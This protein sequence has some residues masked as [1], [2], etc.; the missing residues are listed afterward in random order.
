MVPLDVDAIEKKARAA[1]SADAGIRAEFISIES[2]IAYEK[3]TARG[4]VRILSGGG[5]HTVAR[6]DAAPARQADDHDQGAQRAWDADPKLRAEFMNLENYHAYLKAM[7]SGRVK[8]LGKR[9]AQSPSAAVG[10]SSALATASSPVRPKEKTKQKPAHTLA[11]TKF[12]LEFPETTDAIIAE[13]DGRPVPTGKL[14]SDMTL[15]DFKKE[16]PDIASALIAE[17]RESRM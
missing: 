17:I 7:R 6:K 11:L 5:V 4:M 16:Y 14:D 13:I 12:K 10:N 3:A 9:Q 1:W 15:A 8:I 2:Y